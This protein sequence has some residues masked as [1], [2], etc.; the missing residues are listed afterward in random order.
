MIEITEQI[1][2]RRAQ[3]KL[4]LQASIIQP[5]SFEIFKKTKREKEEIKEA[6]KKAKKKNVLITQDII[7]QIVNSK[8]PRWGSLILIVL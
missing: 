4:E 7:H 3:L 8:T 6:K 1:L 2:Q 5:L